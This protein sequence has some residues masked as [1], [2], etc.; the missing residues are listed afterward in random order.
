V[1]IDDTIDAR[2]LPTTA[3]SVA[4]QKNVADADSAIVTK[5]KAAGAAAPKT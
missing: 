5:L 3:G 2:G 1:L 4:L